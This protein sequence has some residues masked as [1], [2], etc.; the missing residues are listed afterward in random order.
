MIV[1]SHYQAK[2]LL[3]AREAGQEN[4]SSSG[5]LNRTSQEVILDFGF[6]IFDEGLSVPWHLIEEIAG[7]ENA[8]FRIQDQ[9][10]IAISRFSESFNRSYSLY[11]TE[12]AP[13]MLVS[14]IPMHRIKG[15]D[16]WRDT[17]AKIKAL[18]IA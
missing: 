15:T 13:T 12:N 8:C 6:A 16:P 1:L 9:Q 4:I 10:L 11:P 14:G 5:D 18:G 17:Q 7:Q 2:Q 3:A